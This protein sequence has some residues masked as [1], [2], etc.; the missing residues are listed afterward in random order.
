MIAVAPSGASTMPYAAVRCLPPAPVTARVFRCPPREST[1]SS[2]PSPPS[3]IGHARIS[4]SGHTRRK[5]RAM[6]AQIAGAAS[7]PLNE[8][9]AMT[10]IGGREGGMAYDFSSM[11]RPPS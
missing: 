2:V 9:G 1:A 4:A 3:A 6:A 7:E 11:V 8:S 10:T 5:P